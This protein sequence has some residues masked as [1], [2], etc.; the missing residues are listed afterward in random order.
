MDHFPNTWEVDLYAL[1]VVP[2]EGAL[3]LILKP[4]EMKWKLER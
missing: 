3:G 2:K 4:L 1:K